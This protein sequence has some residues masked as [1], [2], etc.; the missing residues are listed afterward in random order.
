MSTSSGA[1]SRATMVCAL[2]SVEVGAKIHD[3]LAELPHRDAVLRRREGRLRVGRRN[4]DCGSQQHPQPSQF[5][6][7][8]KTSLPVAAC[9]RSAHI[10]TREPDC[11]TLTWSKIFCSG[12]GWSL[13]RIK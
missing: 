12:V 5:L 6:F 4:Q 7:P 9:F 13:Y 8:F 3:R 2:A 1:V 11:K 10:G